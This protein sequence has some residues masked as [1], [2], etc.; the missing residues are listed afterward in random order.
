MKKTVTVSLVTVAT[1]GGVVIGSTTAMANDV[2]YA[3][4][5]GIV[6]IPSTEITPPVDPENPGEVV[7]PT[8]PGGETPTPGTAGPLSIDF[9]SSFDFGTQ[10]ITSMDKTYTAIAQKW[11]DAKGNETQGANYVQVTDNRGTLAGWTL[12]VK[13]SNFTTAS[14]LVGSEG[15]TLTGAQITMDNGRIAS[16][17]QLPADK[18]S[19]KT[20][21]TPEVQSGL[22]L[23]AT[24]GNGAGT[25]LLAFGTENTAGS[26]VSLFV[27]GATT[28]LAANYSADLTWLLSDT[29]AN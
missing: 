8:N 4:K 29:P 22:L 14:G 18:A 23:G 3:S 16:A 11:T 9:A 24:T 28:K 6:Y 1:I 21:L 19:A 13:A 12:S 26:S 15:K 2:T 17:S 20:V 10:D 25:S 7:T 5:G 27:P